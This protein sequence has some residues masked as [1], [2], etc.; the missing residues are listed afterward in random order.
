MAVTDVGNRTVKETF[1][2]TSPVTGSAP[3]IDDATDGLP[4]SGDET[5]SATL[6]APSG[7]TLSG[8]GTLNCY[9]YDQTVGLWA[10]CTAGDVTTIPSGSRAFASEAVGVSQGRSSRI[11]W[12]PAGVTF[13]GGGSAGVEVYMLASKG[14]AR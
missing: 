11:K 14:G 13:S 5:A 9:V 8:A 12:I 1:G 3:T 10:R 2:T 7:Q 6:V 4:L